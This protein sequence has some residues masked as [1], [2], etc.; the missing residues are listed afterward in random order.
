[1]PQ[2]PLAIVGPSTDG[3]ASMRTIGAVTYYAL[4]PSTDG[5]WYFR[6]I[7]P[8]DYS[9]AAAI[10]V[11]VVAEATSGVHRIGCDVLFGAEDE[12]ID[13]TETALTVQGITVPSTSKYIDTITFS[14]GLPTAAAGDVIHGRIWRDADGSG[15]TDSLA[16]VTLIAGVYFSYTA[17]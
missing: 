3:A 12:A 5:S 14:S 10:K 4:D 9:S 7:V 11:K 6:G 17:A 8:D 2:Y 16:V 1:M 15:G 13:A